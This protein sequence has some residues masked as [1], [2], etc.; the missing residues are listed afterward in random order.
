[1]QGDNYF[2]SKTMWS[3]VHVIKNEKQTM[4][5]C[6]N[7][8]S[9]FVYISLSRGFLCIVINKPNVENDVP[10]GVFTPY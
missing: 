4:F 6:M 10:L 1:M 3:T 9:L 5:M 2:A 7:T 8:F